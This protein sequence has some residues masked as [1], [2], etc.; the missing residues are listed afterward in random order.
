MRKS[1]AGC[2][3]R[4]FGGLFSGTMGSG[5]AVVVVVVAASSLHSL[6]STS[7]AEREG[8]Y[9]LCL[10]HDT[11]L[12]Q[13]TLANSSGS[14]RKSSS[15]AMYAGFVAGGPD[16]DD[17]DDA[18]DDDIDGAG[19]GWLLGVV[20]RGSSVASVVGHRRSSPAPDSSYRDSPPSYGQTPK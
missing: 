20:K 2:G 16:D 3:F 7:S 15:F 17:D 9:G 10:P 11:G 6:P 13:S 14:L 4:K 18:V 5:G 8:G 1:N 12:D 19:G